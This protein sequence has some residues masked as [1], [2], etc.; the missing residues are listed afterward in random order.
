MLYTVSTQTLLYMAQ[1]L[2]HAGL[3]PARAPATEQLISLLQVLGHAGLL[4]AALPVAAAVMRQ[5]PPPPICLSFLTFLSLL[6]FSVSLSL[7]LSLSHTHTH[8]RARARPVRRVN[9]SLSSRC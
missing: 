7:S 3:L 9:L 4:P 2:G 5:V 8:A 1:V 6:S